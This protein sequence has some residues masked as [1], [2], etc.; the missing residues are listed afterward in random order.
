MMWTCEGMENG[1]KVNDTWDA[2]DI[3]MGIQE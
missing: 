1:E 2:R 3:M